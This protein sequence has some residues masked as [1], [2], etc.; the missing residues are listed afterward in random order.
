MGGARTGVVALAT[1][2]LLA[3]P[4]QAA[5]WQEQ[6]VG[7][8]G[9]SEDV[10]IDPSGNSVAVWAPL[11]GGSVRTSFRP[12]GGTF[13]AAETLDSCGTGYPDVDV[14]GQG[15]F[16]A[17]WVRCDGTVQAATGTGAD[18]F[19]PSETIASA[20]PGEDWRAYPVLDVAPS[21]AA[22]AAWQTGREYESGG[23]SKVRGEAAFR[24]PGGRWEAPETFSPG[25]ITAWNVPADALEVG[26][27][28]SGAAVVLFR[29]WDHDHDTAGYPERALGWDVNPEITQVVAGKA[30][31]GFGEA[32]TVGDG[33]SSPRYLAVGSGGDTLITWIES[34]T[35]EAVAAV[36][37]T[38][39]DP[40]AGDEF[41]AFR[42]PDQRNS[43][44][45][46]HIDGAG[47]A[48]ILF[49]RDGTALLEA[50]SVAGPWSAPESVSPGD[51][52]FLEASAVSEAGELVVAT[53]HYVHGGQSWTDLHLR[54][55]NSADFLRPYVYDD[56]GTWPAVAVNAGRAVALWR[57]GG[58]T[59][60]V[61][62]D[63][64]TPAPTAP[65]ADAR[66]PRCEVENF[67]K[68]SFRVFSF[69][70]ECD[71]TAAL[72][73]TLVMRGVDGA[74][75]GRIS[76]RVRAHRARKLRLRTARKGR[77]ALARASIRRRRV[78]AKLIVT[79]TDAAGNSR[80]V[81]RRVAILAGE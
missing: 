71:E 66:A 44:P 22:I 48:Y 9:G 1:A 29:R 52:G 26:I 6:A 38:T 7:G 54:L 51:A 5:E 76:R 53:Y 35:S 41:E 24:A 40:L 68:R 34:G 13:G 62:D 11:E 58:L 46:P 33:D 30:G 74:R 69:L 64:G 65:A 25:P 80:V 60:H 3:V 28:S 18:G 8:S 45:V 43:N 67:R 21:G 15:N 32:E 70:T 79:A 4:A 20:P 56:G 16:T 77:R 27:D 61:Y 81:R 31:A 36:P 78:A 59:A 63:T 19:G 39:S 75:L 47:R 10:A 12:A 14:D 72:T 57:Y 55:A 73:A 17:L 37:G 42:S 50:P 49:N 23:G 2:V